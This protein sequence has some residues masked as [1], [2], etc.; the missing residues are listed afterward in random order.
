MKRNTSSSTSTG[1]T[2]N[3]YNDELRPLFENTL[4]EFYQS[5][6]SFGGKSCQILPINQD[7]YAYVKNVKSL[8][9]SNLWTKMMEKFNSDNVTRRIK[10]KRIKEIENVGIEDLNNI[11]TFCLLWNGIF[12]IMYK[13]DGNYECG[14]HSVIEKTQ[15]R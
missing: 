5:S 13:G 9:S 4:K 1:S 10:R 15:L 7:K 6:R 12:T 14:L 11:Y 3:L 8:H 2:I